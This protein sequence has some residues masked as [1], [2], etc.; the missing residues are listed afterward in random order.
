MTNLLQI[1]SKPSP[2]NAPPPPTQAWRN[3]LA[4]LATLLF[5]LF[6]G[7][8][9]RNQTL[10]ASQ[11]IDLGDNLPRLSAPVGWLTKRADTGMLQ[12]RNPASASSFASEVDIVTRPLEGDESLEQAR[13]ARSLERSRDLQNYREFSVKEATVRPAIGRSRSDANPAILTT[14]AYVADPSLDSGAN[15]LPIVVQAQDLLFVLDG[16]LYMTTLSADASAWGKEERHFNLVLDSLGY[17]ESQAS[18]EEGSV[19]Q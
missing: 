11:Y 15:G 7:I 12:V 1:L 19:Q 9:V 6:L 2:T 5:A 4:M 14:Y 16:Q 18:A 13:L 3:D 10:N 17:E 8:G